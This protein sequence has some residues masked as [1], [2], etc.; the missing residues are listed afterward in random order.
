M[1]FFSDPLMG[2]L[3][4][5]NLLALMMLFPTAKRLLDDFEPSSRRELMSRFWMS[6]FSDLDIVRPGPEKPPIGFQ[7]GTDE[8]FCS[9]VRRY[10]LIQLVSEYV[11]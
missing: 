9:E 11:V 4:V 2:I 10:I 3:A 6:K 7:T 1:F 8:R 5:V